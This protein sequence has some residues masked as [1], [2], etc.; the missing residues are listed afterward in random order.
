MF[1]SMLSDRHF[2]FLFFWGG[3]GRCVKLKKKKKKTKAALIKE[4]LRL[5]LIPPTL[6]HFSLL[7]TD[8]ARTH[9]FG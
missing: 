8:K 9:N 3:E 4:S 7:S 5:L 1:Q 2:Y 6:P